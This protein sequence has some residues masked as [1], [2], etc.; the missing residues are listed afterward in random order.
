M[1][2]EKEIKEME[3]CTFHPNLSL[4]SKINECSVVSH[5]NGTINIYERLY[6]PINPI[7]FY[8]RT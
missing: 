1:R 5:Y 6:K 3:P 8:E 2:L 7:E 4:N